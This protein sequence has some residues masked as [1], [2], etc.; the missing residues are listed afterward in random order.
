MKKINLILLIEDDPIT[1]YINCRIIKKMEFTSEIEVALNGQEALSLIQDRIDTNKNCPDLIFLDINM[2][3]M[4]GF[5]FL[6][7]FSKLDFP[8]KEKVVIIMLSTSTHSKDMDRL[9]FFNNLELIA[10]P[11]NKEKLLFVINKYFN[12]SSLSK[13]A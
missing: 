7:R 1:N 8:N 10:K 2:P 6:D 9:V 13:I 3:V 5:E 12:P 11:L 4:D